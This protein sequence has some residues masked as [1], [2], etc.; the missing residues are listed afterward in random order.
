MEREQSERDKVNL[1]TD[2]Q[3]YVRVEKKRESEMDK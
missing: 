2:Q 1:S 3:M